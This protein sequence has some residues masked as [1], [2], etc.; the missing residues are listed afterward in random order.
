MC[1]SSEFAVSP[2]KA[3]LDEVRERL[4][5][6]TE[7]F[8]NVRSSIGF[9]RCNSKQIDYNVLEFIWSLHISLAGNSSRAFAVCNAPEGH[10]NATSE[11]RRRDIHRPASKPYRLCWSR[12]CL[13]C[14]VATRQERRGLPAVGEGEWARGRLRERDGAEG[15]CRLVG[16][17]VEPARPNCSISM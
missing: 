1:S 9:A 17:Q 14:V 15:A 16:G 7:I 5:P 8:K 4:P 6:H 13:S 3:R 10:A 12:C 2:A 11:T